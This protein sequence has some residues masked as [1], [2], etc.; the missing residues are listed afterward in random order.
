[1]YQD[2][3]LTLIGQ[4]VDIPYLAVPLDREDIILVITKS[5]KTGFDAKIP[6]AFNPM[7]S[8]TD[9]PVV[10]C[11]KLNSPIFLEFFFS[12]CSPELANLDMLEAQKRGN[13][14]I[15]AKD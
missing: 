11:Q 2:W 13:Q 8:T 9:V 5:E 14:L 10:P 15:V 3:E 1:V 12:F 6:S 4:L 7:N